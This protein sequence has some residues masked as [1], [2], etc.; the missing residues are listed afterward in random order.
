MLKQMAIEAH[1]L[2]LALESSKRQARITRVVHDAKKALA[3]II[4][5]NS[6]LGYD[7]KLLNAGESVVRLVVG[8]MHFNVF[9]DGRVKFIILNPDG[10]MYTSYHVDN[11]ADIGEVLCKH[12]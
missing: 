10:T 2:R 1:E 9:S 11:L 12:E 6:E 5:P 4:D 8:D 3:K 7:I